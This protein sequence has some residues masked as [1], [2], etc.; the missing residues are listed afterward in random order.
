MTWQ[1]DLFHWQPLP[2]ACENVDYSRPID[3][4]YFEEDPDKDEYAFYCKHYPYH[5]IL[6]EECEGMDC[7]DC[8]IHGAA[9]FVAHLKAVE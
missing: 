4:Q 5:R 8:K 6:S 9:D 1:T 3:R 7:P 2:W